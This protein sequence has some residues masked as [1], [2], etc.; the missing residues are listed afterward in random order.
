MKNRKFSRNIKKTPTPCS[1]QVQNIPPNLSS[2]T[3]TRNRSS[4][5]KTDGS[6]VKKYD[7][8]VDDQHLAKLNPTHIRQRACD[9]LKVNE[10]LVEKINKL[11]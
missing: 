7:R 9:L 3:S 8:A 1:Q 5:K 11:K 10:R 2:R 4:T 6:G